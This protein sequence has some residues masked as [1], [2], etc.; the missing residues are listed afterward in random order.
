[1]LSCRELNLLGSNRELS[2]DEAFI[3]VEQLIVSARGPQNKCGVKPQFIYLLFKDRHLN[4]SNTGV[5]NQLEI[6][7]L[8]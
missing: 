8:H 5:A 2:A 7:A 4:L 3:L 6:A 1:M